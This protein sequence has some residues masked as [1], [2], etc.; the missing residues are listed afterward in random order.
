MILSTHSKT[1]K[2]DSRTHRYFPGEI[3]PCS[4]LHLSIVHNPR[5]KRGFT[6]AAEESFAMLSEQPLTQARH[7]ASQTGNALTL[8]GNTRLPPSLAQHD[9]NLL[10]PTSNSQARTHYLR[11][12][13]SRA[14]S[15]LVPGS[16]GMCR[17]TIVVGN[18]SPLVGPL[19]SA[20]LARGCRPRAAPLLSRQDGG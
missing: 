10:W 6:S 5:T 11:V 2:S 18:H 13:P 14:P 8:T 3:M 17:R 16:L 15:K 9:I 1:L 20:G 12:T 19:C 7:H 4:L